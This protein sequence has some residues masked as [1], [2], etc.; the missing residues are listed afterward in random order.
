LCYLHG[1]FLHS[2]DWTSR[3]RFQVLGFAIEDL[4][5]VLMS[6]DWCD[7]HLFKLNFIS[8]HHLLYARRLTFKLC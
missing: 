8:N 4:F 7:F 3:F 6:Y 5:R 1:H 2:Y